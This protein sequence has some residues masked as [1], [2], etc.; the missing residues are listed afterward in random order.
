VSAPSTGSRPGCEAVKVEGTH[1]ERYA[2]VHSV[3]LGDY[4]ITSRHLGCQAL[5]EV[6]EES[7]RFT[8]LVFKPGHKLALPLHAPLVCQR[9]MFGQTPNPTS[10]GR[11]SRDCCIGIKRARSREVSL[12]EPLHEAQS[13]PHAERD[14][15]PCT[16][17][18]ARN[19]CRPPS[20]CFLGQG[21]RLTF[22]EKRHQ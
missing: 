13:P 11:S 7:V 3:Q 4:S 15:H 8:Q 19:L 1:T 22:R 21:R 16:R 14:I 9:G 2:L 6:G 5:L 18:P 12:I 10:S 17:V 20:S